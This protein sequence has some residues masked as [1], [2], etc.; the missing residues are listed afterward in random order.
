MDNRILALTL[1]AVAILGSLVIWTDYNRSQDAE[2][3]HQLLLDEKE[4]A[5]QLQVLEKKELEKQRED[6]QKRREEEEKR[7][8]LDRLAQAENEKIESEIR[9]KTLEAIQ[10]IKGAVDSKGNG[11]VE[12]KDAEE[13][14]TKQIKNAQVQLTENQQFEYSYQTGGNQETTVKITFVIEDVSDLRTISEAHA[15]GTYELLEIP[16][17]YGQNLFRH[18]EHKKTENDCQKEKKISTFRIF[19]TDKKTVETVK[20]QFELLKKIQ[21]LD[22]EAR[23]K[24]YLAG[25]I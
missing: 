24:A 4:K 7:K 6:A 8:E 10:K 5:F 19:L 13:I 14:W 2:R 25:E 21:S 11:Y 23:K 3:Q 15:R 17:V 20:E 16:A 12:K 18:C 9:K 22:A 1:V